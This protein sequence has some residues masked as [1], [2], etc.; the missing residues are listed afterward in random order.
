MLIGNPEP[1]AR[2][3]AVV[4]GRVRCWCV[5]TTTP[6][7]DGDA[8]VLRVNGEVDAATDAVLQSGIAEAFA[9]YPASLVV[10]LKG[11]TF[12]SGR[13]LQLLVEAQIVA[14]A[15]RTTYALS[16]VPRWI[17]RLW[18]VICALD[19]LPR[20]HPTAA[21]AVRAAQAVASRPGR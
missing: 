5:T 19:D 4:R 11:V 10:D 8:I 6:G 15:Y 14:A 13:A 20:R 3:E 12:C 16:G 9:R 18:P 1:S 7:A 2:H 21:A 17:D